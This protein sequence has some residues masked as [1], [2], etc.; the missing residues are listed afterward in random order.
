MHRRTIKDS[1]KSG[2]RPQVDVRRVILD[3]LFA[4]HGGLK[5]IHV[6]PV[7][8]GWVNTA[9]CSDGFKRTLTLAD[10]TAL[11]KPFTPERAN[12]FARTDGP[13]FVGQ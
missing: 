6:R 9:V 4:S 2:T 8:G 13:P 5:S 7:R 11:I 3:Q 1:A 10:E 12:K